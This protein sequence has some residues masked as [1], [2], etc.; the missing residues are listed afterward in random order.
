MGRQK[1]D[2]EKEREKTQQTLELMMV[3]NS[4]FQEKLKQLSA[5]RGIDFF[6][7]VKPK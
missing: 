4:R 3:T 7:S 5:C 2:I 6:E 1:S